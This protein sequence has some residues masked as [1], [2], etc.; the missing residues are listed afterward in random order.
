MRIYEKE[1]FMQK[2]LASKILVTGAAGFIGFHLAQKLCNEGAQVLGYDNLNDYY[3]VS[4]KEARLAE[5][6]KLE[7]FTFIK[8]DLED[9]AAMEKAF[10]DFKPDIVIHLAA[11]AG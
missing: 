10:A 11:Q 3:D 6:Q 9:D 1:C 5:L 4:L 7:N 2:I 8:A